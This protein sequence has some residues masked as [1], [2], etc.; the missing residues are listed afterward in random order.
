MPQLAQLLLVYQSQWFWLL[1]TLAILYFGIGKWIVPGVEQ[2]VDNRDAKIAADLAAAEQARQAAAAAEEGWQQKI[3]AVHAE[4][5]ATAAKARAEAAL[6]AEKQLAAADAELAQRAHE[7]NAR[8]AEAR[9]AALATVGDVAADAA[10]EIV[11]K[12]S[13]AS[14]SEEEARSAVKAAMAHG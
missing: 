7:A 1:I 6:A 5:H 8:L 11:A 10:R 13:G 14:V 12:I 4:A 3:A 2:T 9:N